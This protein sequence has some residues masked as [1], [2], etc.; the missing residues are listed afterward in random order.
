MR[1][2]GSLL[3]WLW[4]RTLPVTIVAAAAV[5]ALALLIPVRLQALFL[6]EW[7]YLVVLVVV[8]HSVALAAC[9]GRPTSGATGYLYSRGFSRDRLWVHQWLASA[10]SVLAVWLPAG[11]I[12]WTPLRG[13]AQWALGNPFYPG[14]AGLDAAF[15][16]RPLPLYGLLLPLLHYSWIRGV[17][18]TRERWIGPILVTWGLFC[19]LPA[20]F[21]DRRDTEGL[22]PW[23]LGCL[24]AASLVLVLMSWRL[25]RR[26][27]VG[28]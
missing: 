19:L 13:W 5:A 2:S 25:H 17:Q 1:L 10:V 7:S 27:E 3:V 20:A 15:P 11:L 12:V 24:A 28:S 9:Q 4:R 26:M 22:M 16:L 8:A 21:L 14:A 23:T 6:E 18:P